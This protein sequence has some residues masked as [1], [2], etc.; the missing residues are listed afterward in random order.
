MKI[1]HLCNKSH[2]FLFFTNQSIIISRKKFTSSANIL[3]YAI[4]VFITKKNLIQQ[5]PNKLEISIFGHIYSLFII[6]KIAITFWSLC[7][8]DCLMRTIKKTKWKT[9]LLKIGFYNQ[10]TQ[11]SLDSS[12]LTHKNLLPTI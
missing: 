8:Y 4:L 9:T 5:S 2:T 10:G 1:K 12:L 11:L 6:I 7:F 3:D